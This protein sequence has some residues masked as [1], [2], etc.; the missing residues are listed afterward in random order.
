M[1]AKANISANDKRLTDYF[2]GILPHVFQK[3]NIVLRSKDERQVYYAIASEMV[4]FARANNQAGMIS[5]FNAGEM[6]EALGK[7]QS[8]DFSSE[9]EEILRR[10]SFTSRGNHK[11]TFRLLVGKFWS[12]MID[13]SGGKEFSDDYQGNAVI[14]VR[15]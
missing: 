12:K 9:A 8:M 13:L 5:G 2:A 14:G 6:S 4:Q 1:T 11:T 7:N 10:M 15:G 3:M